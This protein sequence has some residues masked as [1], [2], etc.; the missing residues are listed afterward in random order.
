MLYYLK[1]ED[2]AARKEFAQTLRSA[3]ISRGCGA[4]ILLPVGDD[5][6]LQHQIEKIIKGHPLKPGMKLADVKFKP[7]CV[8]IYDD[9]TKPVLEAIEKVLPGFTEKNGPLVTIP[10][11]TQV[12]AKK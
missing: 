11:E 5:H 9:E 1:G 3:T 8:V 6:P 10:I 7:G 4:L 12:P 2:A